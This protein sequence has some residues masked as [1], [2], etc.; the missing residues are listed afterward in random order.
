M[1]QQRNALC[2][3]NSGKKY[4]KCHGHPSYSIPIPTS[5]I[6]QDQKDQYPHDRC[7]VPNEYRAECNNKIIRA[8]T[9]SKSINLNPIAQNEHVYSFMGSNFSQLIKTNGKFIA[10][11]IS[12]KKASTFGGFCDKH[13]SE[14]FKALDSGFDF[15]SEQIFLNYYRTLVRELYIKEK[16]VHHQTTI[17]KSYDKGLS[18]IQQKRYQDFLF[19]A[20]MGMDIGHRDLERIKLQMDKKLVS[21]K[22]TSMKYYGILIDTIP[23][24]ISTCVWVVSCDFENNQL[25]DLSNFSK[26]YNSISVST[27]ILSDKQGVI[28]FSWNDEISSPECYSFIQNLHKLSDSEKIKACVYWLF[29]INENIY[30]APAWWEALEKTKQ[31]QITDIFN[32]TLLDKKDLSQYNS[33]DVVNWNIKEIKTNISL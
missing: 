27:L 20:S 26:F 6:I 8:H 16:N 28:L 1:K 15:T 5:Q 9:I 17:M 30:F 31:Q 3:C 11:K 10:E 7:Y 19:N 32:N 23:D 14:I 4:K 12:V 33:L 29:A 24:I 2:W 22:F 18:P 21:K 25:A 13:D